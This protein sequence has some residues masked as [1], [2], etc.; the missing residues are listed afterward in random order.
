MVKIVTL[1]CRLN[2]YDSARIQKLVEDCGE[3]IVI[4]NTCTVTGNADSD[5]RKAAR[6]MKRE[7]PDSKVIVFGCAVRGNK[8]LFD[9]IREIDYLV[10]D[11]EGLMALLSVEAKKSVIPKFIGRTRA[12][13]KIQEGCNRKCSYCIVPLVRG[14]S[15]SRP[16]QEVEKEFEGLINAGYKEVVL[17]GT[18]IADFGR[19]LKEKVDLPSLL[20]KLLGKGEN[21][22]L[23]L[24]SIESGS[25]DDELIAVIAES[26]GRIAE[27]LHIAIQSGSEKVL[28]EMNRDSDIAKLKKTIFKLEKS[29]PGVGIGADFINA[30]PAEG[31][32][33]FGETVNFI[34][35]MPLAFLHVFTFSPRRNTAA[36]QFQPL[37]KEI[38]DER[39]KELMVL[40]K[41]KRLDFY[42]Q[43]EG[44]ALRSLTLENEKGRGK[45]LSGNF[46]EFTTEKIYEPNRFIDFELQLNEGSEPVGIEVK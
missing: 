6:K 12:M 7:N 25:I 39:K 40:A 13:I 18:H 14:K 41:R 29:I 22:R 19:G 28:K 30:F 43:N 3:D 32:K 9:G 33:E 16:L 23:R 27:H 20:R 26:K 34:K 1:G 8:G 5:A 4:I 11:E 35:E 46:I 42:K 2:Q 17:T 31:E 45:A 38:A 21:F 24:S 10:R 36:F 37:R 44:K 15:R